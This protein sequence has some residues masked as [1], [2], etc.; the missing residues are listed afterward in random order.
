MKQNLTHNKNQRHP[1]NLQ[2]NAQQEST[3]SSQF[4]LKFALGMSHK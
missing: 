1:R 4:T 3:S 2:F